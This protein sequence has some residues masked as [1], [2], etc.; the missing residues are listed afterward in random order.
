M[1]IQFEKLGTKEREMLISGEFG[2]EKESLRVTP[3]GNLAHTPHPFP[4]DKQR[5]R[6]FCENQV[7]MIT[8]VKYTI[9]D[10]YQELLDIHRETVRTLLHLDS[11]PEYLWPFS[12]PPYVKNES[13]IPVAEFSGDLAS[14]TVYRQY[15]AKKYG[16]KK[17]LYS[18]I[19]FNFSFPEAVLGADFEQKGLQN[20]QEY[21]NA[22]YLDLAGKVLRKSW[23]IVYLTAASPVFDGS[24]Y[25][26]E[27]LGQ[28]RIS[29]YASPRCS[30]IGYW[31]QFTPTLD[32]RTLSGYIDSIQQY[33][34]DGQLKASSELY[35]PVRVKPKALNTL[36]NLRQMGINHIEL[37]MFDLNPLS[38]IGIDPRDLEFVFYLLEYLA[39]L[40]EDTVSDAEQ[41]IAI[42]N[43][44]Q[45]AVLN[46]DT[47]MIE[48]NWNETLPI[49]DAVKQE[50]NR[51][52]ELLIQVLPADRVRSCIAH[53]RHKVEYP[54]ARYADR[55]IRDFEKSFVKE[56]MCLAK[57]RADDLLSDQKQ[58]TY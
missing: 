57:K 18:G 40:P 17:M 24:F 11:G 21:K 38:E 39:F 56:G 4:D 58:K 3:A 30:E 48:T 44:K 23:L 7:E 31:N 45:A 14:K 22:L 13:D 35:Y 29:R 26:P 10:L 41:I 20:F 25:R 49:R 15:L 27:D 50:L 5:D 34:D 19:H 46:S 32:F 54:N 52:E 43:M 47:I 9:P 36:D 2:L 12:N 28:D 33:I 1:G 42:R 55:I 37:R 51:M 16:K 53:Q 6:D 8:G